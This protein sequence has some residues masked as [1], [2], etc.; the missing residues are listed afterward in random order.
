[1]LREG[2]TNEWIRMSDSDDL[3]SK[4]ARSKGLESYTCPGETYS[5]SYSIHLARLAAFYS[6]C[7]DCEHRFDAEHIFPRENERTPLVERRVIRDSLLTAE[8]VRGVYLNELDRN[9]A[10]AWGEAFAALMW[11]QQPMQARLEPT[12]DAQIV[13]QADSNPVSLKSSGPTVVVGFDERPS[14]PD[15]VTGAVLGLRRMGCAVIDLGQTALPIVAFKLQSSAA[16]GAVYVTGAGGAASMTGFE[17]LTRNGLPISDRILQHLEANARTGVGRQTRQIGHHTPLPGQSD[18]EASLVPHFHAL[19]PLKIV[20]GSSTRL[21]PRILDR[22]F[23]KLPCRMTH[24]PLPVRSRNLEDSS[25]ADL[26]RVAKSVV[27]SHSHLGI[28]IDEDGRRIAFITDGGRL[29]TPREVARILIEFVQREKEAAQFVAATPLMTDVSNWLRGRSATV[30]DGGATVH[31]L[32]EA[33]VAQNAEFALA[34]DGRVWFDPLRPTCDAFLVVAKLLQALSLSD[35]PFSE[36][37]A[38]IT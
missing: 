10:I 38:R 33:F 24:L 27:D 4:N 35:T 31:S 20:C 7:I 5:I 34:G 6:K 26:Q 11:N 12:D 1:M 30:T 23:S 36:V 2:K 28:V 15:I 19:R 17:L 16:N 22:L 29:V 9:R 13:E 21:T 32:V 3:K 8:S 14:S 25:D 37:V 18:Y